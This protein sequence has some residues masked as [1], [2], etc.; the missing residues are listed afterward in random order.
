[1]EHGSD[2]WQGNSLRSLPR[3]KCATQVMNADICQLGFSANAFPC[4]SWL[5]HEADARSPRKEYFVAISAASASFDYL[6]CIGNEGDCD[7]VAVLPLSRTL[8]VTRDLAESH[9]QDVRLSSTGKQKQHEKVA[10]VFSLVFKGFEE[11]CQF[12]RS[13]EAFS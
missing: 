5:H 1:M 11:P 7:C 12:V 6:D 2:D 4:R 9:L 8:Y 10:D 13:Q 3:A